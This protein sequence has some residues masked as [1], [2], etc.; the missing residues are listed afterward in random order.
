MDSVHRT[1]ADLNRRDIRVLIWFQWKKSL[2]AA[3]CYEEL[4]SVLG[5]IGPSYATVKN[6][7]R[8]FNRGKFELEDDPRPG[9]P[10][11]SVTEENIATIKQMI[12]EERHLTV[13]Q[14]HEHLG[15]S[16]GSVHEILR[17]HLQVRKLC[18]IWIPHKL[19]DEQRA[20]RVTWC[21][22]MLQKFDHGNSRNVNS[23]VTG[24]ET[25]VYYYD[26]PSRRQSR[27]WVFE[28]EAPPVQVRRQ[29]SVGK[30]MYAIFFGKSGLIDAVM[31]E[32]KKT[33]TA[34]WYTQT[35]LPRVFE[36]LKSRRPKSPMHFW[37]LHHDNAPG[38]RAQETKAFLVNS[39]IKVLE[40]P[41]YSPDLAPCDFGLFPLVKDK[42][43]GRWFTN[44]EELESAL[45]DAIEDLDKDIWNR[46]FDDWFRRMQKCVSCGGVYFEKEQQ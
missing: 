22:N 36:E 25:L 9:R 40:H 31:L 15:I 11:T 35:C 16:V 21:Q 13:H 44:E 42:L 30:R 8:Q 26:V 3:Q 45:M 2:T 17:D 7:Y 33:V 19:T 10:C 18:T 34:S 23:I 12:T 20:S 1:M 29:R 32:N 41:P 27:V 28:D 37:H 43:K 4:V 38:H 6:W 46:I 39:G 5:N 14:I 24:D